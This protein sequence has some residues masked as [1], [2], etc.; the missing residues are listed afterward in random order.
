MK[1]NYILLLVCLITIINSNSADSQTIDVGVTNITPLVI[2]TDSTIQSVTVEIFNSGQTS[3]SNI[4][5]R[6][7]LNGGNL[8]WETCYSSILPGDTAVFTFTQQLSVPGWLSISYLSVYVGYSGDTNSYNNLTYWYH[9]PYG[10][11]CSVGFTYG[12]PYSPTVAGATLYQYDIDWWIFELSNNYIDVTVSLCGSSFDTRLEVYAN[13]NSFYIGYNDNYCGSQS[14]LHFTYLSAG[15]YYVKIFGYGT[16]YGS[17]FL[18]IT[19]IPASPPPAI[20]LLV[21]DVSCNGDT[22]GAI[23]LTFNPLAGI[24]LPFMYQW[25]N[26][27]TTQDLNNISAGLYSVTVTD[28]NGTQFFDSCTVSE[29]DIVL[30]TGFDTPVTTIGGN[31]GSIDLW[32]NGGVAPY[33][34]LWSNSEIVEDPQNLYGGMYNVTVTDYLGCSLGH[35]QGDHHQ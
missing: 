26:N 4:P 29:P 18:N 12:N 7:S 13:C 15:T 16:E 11:L 25:S 24:T 9:N 33:S 10:E 22:D 31:N 17:Y 2:L 8:V 3:V 35:W 30:V 21:S 28:A 6:Y 1:K 14:E 23:D 32:V 34:F 20:G 27:Q 5:V 19:G